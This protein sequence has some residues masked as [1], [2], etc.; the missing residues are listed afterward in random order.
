MEKSLLVF[1]YVYLFKLLY[2]G[3]SLFKVQC[4][5]VRAWMEC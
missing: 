4:V 5:N 1:G 3:L 2:V